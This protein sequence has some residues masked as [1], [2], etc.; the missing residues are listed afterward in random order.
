MTASVSSLPEIAAGIAARRE[1]AIAQ[2][3]ST[4][5]KQCR[6]HAALMH[7]LAALITT[8]ELPPAKVTFAF[9]V[10]GPE[11]EVDATGDENVQN[12]VRRYAAALGL[13]PVIESPYDAPGGFAA[14]RWTASGRDGTGTWFFVHGYELLPVHE[15]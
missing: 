4:V 15:R 13:P 12:V 1:Q 5:S 6:P 11:V 14:I 8:E 9:T 7:R 2:H 10:T 3:P